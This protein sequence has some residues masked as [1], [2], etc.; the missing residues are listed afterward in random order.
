MT[1]IFW[2]KPLDAGGH[3][4]FRILLRLKFQ[5]RRHKKESQDANLG[6]F[7]LVQIDST[8]YVLNE[9]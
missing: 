5:Y 6:Q 1:K 9:S 3:E 7:K 8:V 4:T 2:G